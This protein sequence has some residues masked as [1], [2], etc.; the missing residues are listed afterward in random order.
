LR[1][2]SVLS[3]HTEEE[4]IS[5]SSSSGYMFFYLRTDVLE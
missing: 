5:T 2:D 4:A 1:D 3:W